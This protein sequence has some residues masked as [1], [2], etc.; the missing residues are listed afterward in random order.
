MLSAQIIREQR[1]AEA[2]KNLLCHFLLLNTVVLFSVCYIS[3]VT[4]LYFLLCAKL[5]C[6][7]LAIRESELQ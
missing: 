2:E 3:S 7:V 1:D 6:H 5:S 4:S